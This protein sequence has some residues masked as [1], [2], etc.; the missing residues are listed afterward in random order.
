MQT[1]FRKL[2]VVLLM[3]KNYVDRFVVFAFVLSLG[4]FAQPKVSG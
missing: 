4:S 1:S 2:S 3:A